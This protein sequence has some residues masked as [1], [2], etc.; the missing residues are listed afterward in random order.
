MGQ[1]PLCFDRDET[2]FSTSMTQFLRNSLGSITWYLCSYVFNLQFVHTSSSKGK[3]MLTFQD[4]LSDFT[5]RNHPYGAAPNT[6][7]PQQCKKRVKIVP[8]LNAGLARLLVGAKSSSSAWKQRKCVR[9][10]QA[11]SKAMVRITM[12]AAAVVVTV[13][14]P[15]CSTFPGS[16]PASGSCS[17]TRAGSGGPWALWFALSAPP[18]LPVQHTSDGT[19]QGP[20]RHCKR[21]R[22]Y[23]VLWHMP[24]TFYTIIDS[25]FFFNL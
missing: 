23:F 20:G 8:W 14:R 25:S 4:Q 24:I 22:C 9:R 21:G 3:W 6:S 12:M 5:L 19:S 11:C 10:K 15:A 1:K 13:R 2:I 17:R 16:L 18:P 7:K